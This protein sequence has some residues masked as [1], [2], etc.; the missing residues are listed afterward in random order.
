MWLDVKNAVSGTEFWV[1]AAAFATVLVLVWTLRGTA[2]L[3]K[4]EL[5]D[6][7]EAPAAGRRDRIV[8]AMVFGLMLILAGG[9][10]AITRG[11]AWSLPL[12]GLGFGLVIALMT[13]NQRY[14]H[15]SPSVRRTIDFASAFLNATLVGGILI[16]VN[17]IAFRYWSRPIDLTREGTYTLSSTTLNQLH[18]LDRPLSFTLIFGRGPR[19]VRQRERLD[20]LLE[21]Y[22]SANPAFVR[23]TR[24]DQFAD[25]PRI[26]ELA[27]RM[28]E[29][30]PARGGGLL[31]ELGDGDPPESVVVRG[32]DLFQPVSAEVAR[33]LS[34]RFESAFKGEDEITSALVRLREGKRARVGFTV[35]H[36]ERSLADLT[37][38][39]TGIGNWK[40][41]LNK[42]ACDVVELNL[43][44]DEIPP[45][46]SLLVVVAPRSPFKP[47]EVT[48]LDAYR[49]AGRPLL[50]LLGNTDSHGLDQF[51][52]RYNLK[53]AD[54]LLIDP[55]LNYNKTPNLVFAPI[56][57]EL[58][59][60]IV[61]GMGN[62]RAVLLPNAAPIRVMGQG[63]GDGK[64]TTDAVDPQMVPTAFLRSSPQGWGETDRKSRPVQFDAKL[65]E[66]GPVL[67]GVAVSHREPP[68]GPDVQSRFTPRLVLISCPSLG[69]NIFQEI[70]P[71]N[72]D[73]LMN[74][75]SWLRDRPNTLGLPAQ[76]HV[77]LT[78]TASP[79]LQSRLVMVPTV[80]SVL[81]IIAIGSLVY[82]AR[83]E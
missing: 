74:A 49:E 61:D 38:N 5:E 20:Q 52:L 58:S 24:L 64:T 33:S 67:V 11:I 50:L 39:G 25:Q 51:L 14:R 62:N 12:F 44:K 10:V 45:E 66:R 48:K 78:L 15:G 54:G 80:V 47:E 9:Y 34:E 46:L 16:V 55:S 37:P 3:Q 72:L 31:I 35:G 53:I 30:D 60:P 69:D 13:V 21:S 79:L 4:A 18:S 65:D 43:L 29:V 41:R 26:E 76:T 75:A 17:V 19:A 2:P 1:M 22:R 56:S 82:V 59:H 23:I 73:L 27:K 83:R 57:G 77:A 70:E 42:V 68:Y 71:T 6:D 36:G 40:A 81:L 63:T 8:L 7:D 28:P 32:S